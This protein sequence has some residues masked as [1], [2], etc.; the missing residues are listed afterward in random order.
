MAKLLVV[1]DHALVREGLVQTLS[2]LDTKSAIVETRDAESALQI[3][4]SDDEFDLV[5]L[6]LMLPGINGMAFL[7]VL[8]RRFPA[9][10]V[11][12][13]S[14]L[15]DT[16]TISRAM[17]Q[18]ASGFVPK[19]SSSDVL[20]QALRLVLDGG[21]YVPPRAIAKGVG[22]RGGEGARSSRSLVDRFGLTTGQMRV[23]ELLIQ[24]KSNREIGEL[25]G[26]T[27]GT[28]KIHVSKIFK[29]LNVSSRAQAM[30]A[31]SRYRVKA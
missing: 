15:D 21:V 19:T 25:L 2:Q 29:A 8:R 9:V 14:A 17:R 5:L 27:E 1:E 11:V 7:A 22:K 3:L 28:V 13:I 23:L 31:L 30:V 24:G 18:G 26:L 4:E 20:L 16:E 12:I 10:P 6:D